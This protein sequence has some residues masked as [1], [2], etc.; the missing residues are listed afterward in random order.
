MVSFPRCIKA[1][2]DINHVLI[3]IQIYSEGYRK[4]SILHA[5]LRYQCSSL[6]ADLFHISITNN[7]KCQCGAPFEDSIHYLMESPLYQNEREC[8]FRNL[9]ETQQNIETL[10]FGN[11]EIN[12]NENSMK[13]GIHDTSFTSKSPFKKTWIK[14][15]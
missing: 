9:G 1:S 14:K 6:N 10:R 12:I 3:Q 8:L 11:D 7:P 15:N 5:R 2:N 13:P 4:L